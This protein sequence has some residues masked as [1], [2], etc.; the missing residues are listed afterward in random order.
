MPELPEVETARRSL[1]PLIV[2][3]RIER[4][5]VFR[6]PSL[7]SHRPAEAARL[8]GGR[9]IKGVQRRGK[10]LLFAL[11][12]GW[13]LVF[14]FSLGGVIRVRSDFSPDAATAVALHLDD[15]QVIE[16]RELQ[17]ST[18]N[19][20]TQ[21]ELDRAPYLADLGPDPLDE[22]VTLPRFR[23]AL[24]GRGAIRPLLSD[25]TRLAGIGNLW[26]QEILFA[27]GIRPM[28]RAQTLSDRE[29][30]QLY[31]A[32][33]S[34]LRRAVRAGGEPDFEDAAGRRGRCRL[35]VYGRGGQP[36]PR[37]GARIVSTRVGGRPAFYCPRCQ[38]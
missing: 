25:Q 28:R 14:H 37:C 31:R 26:S 23:E 12:G 9:T 8:V 20:Y 21:A 30:A 5:E 17:L 19:I 15:G 16:F 13:W 24:A 38:R 6:P 4:L 34:T 7:R 29:W 3:R 35:A 1:E 32:M 27:A 36:C 22:A 2:G 18:L 33:R 10:A 11:D